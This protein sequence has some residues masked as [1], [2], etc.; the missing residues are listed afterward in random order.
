MMTAGMPPM[1]VRVL[2]QPANDLAFTKA[3]LQDDRHDLL[4][5]S[6][7]HRAGSDTNAHSLVLYL[8]LLTQNPFSLRILRRA[9]SYA[10]AL[11]TPPPL[12]PDNVLYL[13]LSQP[14]K[15]TW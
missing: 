11:A 9:R 7:K 3:I 6:E 13:A 2:G 15:V 8:K 14:G 5:E 12:V 1:A 10:A 4:L